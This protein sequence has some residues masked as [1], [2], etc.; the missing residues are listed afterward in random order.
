VA[1]LEQGD[2][3]APVL[4][5]LGDFVDDYAVDPQLRN[6]LG[7]VWLVD[8]DTVEAI[9]LHLAYRATHLAA[10]DDR[11]WIA[12]RLTEACAPFGTEVVEVADRYRLRPAEPSST[13]P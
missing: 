4:Y 10:G 7:V 2:D 13:G 5:D 3:R 1:F 8:G 12:R 9:P 6:D 11:R